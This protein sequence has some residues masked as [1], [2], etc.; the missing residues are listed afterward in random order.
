MLERV[1]PFVADSDTIALSTLFGCSISLEN[2]E[3]NVVTIQALS[4]CESA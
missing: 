2:L 4:K 1:Y 3:G